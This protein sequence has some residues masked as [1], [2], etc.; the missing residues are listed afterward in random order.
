[1]IS[2]TDLHIDLG[3]FHL[4]DINLEV[5]ENEF[6]I[7]MGPSGSGKTILL[8]TIAGLVQPKSGRIKIGSEEITQLPPEKR[9]ISIVYQDYALFPHLTVVENVR[10]GL[11]FN[12]ADKAAGEIRLQE[13]LILLNLGGLE[14]RYPET[15][16]GGEQQRVAMA[17]A[18]VVNPKVLLLDEPLSALDPRLR[19]EFRLLLK[20]LQQNTSAT[21]LMVTHDFSEALALGGRGAVMN[22]GRIEQAGSMEDI[23][24]RPESTMVAD[25][26]GMKNLFAVSIDSETA[27][28]GTL[29]IH[30]GRSDRNGEHFI[31]IRPEDIVLSAEQLH[32]SMRNSFKGEISQIIPQGFYYEIHIEVDQVKF[33]A[34][35][36]KG[37]LLEMELQEGGEIFLFFKSTAIHTF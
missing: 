19:E 14:K 17:R 9:G 7:I 23:F 12:K 11:H 34:L 37:A 29:Q 21:I 2:V 35:V 25:F 6:F 30:L 22:G 24:Q 8:E 4:K 32:S 18:L 20:Q 10:Y 31:A 1:M 15:L 13:L 26:V 16:S 28:I 5:E 36:T 27:H 3:E 33:C